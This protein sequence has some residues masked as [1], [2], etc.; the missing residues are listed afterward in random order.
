MDLPLSVAG[1]ERKKGRGV[2]KF[3]TAFFVFKV[4]NGLV[5]EKI[6]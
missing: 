6:F 4:M 5:S 2:T 1:G 3:R